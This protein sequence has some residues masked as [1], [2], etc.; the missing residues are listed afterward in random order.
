MADNK[1]FLRVD[2]SVIMKGVWSQNHWS[3]ITFGNIVFYIVNYV[4]ILFI[5][6]FFWTE[7]LHAFSQET[8]LPSVAFHPEHLSLSVLKWSCL[9]SSLMWG[10][11]EMWTGS[12]WEARFDAMSLLSRLSFH[13]SFLLAFFLFLSSHK[14]S[15]TCLLLS[16]SVMYAQSLSCHMRKHS[17]DIIF[18]QLWHRAS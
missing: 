15:P 2:H 3:L 11:C 16:Q 13:P 6:L 17:F 5:Y 12:V 10:T 1:L 14:I 4:L 9:N 7:A 18:A 8:P